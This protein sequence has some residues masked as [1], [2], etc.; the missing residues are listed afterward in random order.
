MVKKQQRLNGIFLILIVVLLFSSCNGGQPEITATPTLAP[1]SVPT[2]T[3]VP[4]TATPEPERVVWIS[5][6]DN[7]ATQ[8]LSAV[9]QSLA[10]SAGIQFEAV[11]SLDSNQINDS[12]RVAVFHTPNYDVSVAAAGHPNTQFIVIGNS[13]MA[14]VDNLTVIRSNP[15]HTLFAAG[16]LSMILSYD[17]RGAGLIASDSGLGD[18]AGWA[19]KNG[20]NYFCGRCSPL[21]PPYVQFPLIVMQPGASPAG[22]WNAGYEGIS[23][24]RLNTIFIDANITDP[25]VYTQMAD[26]G[27]T[28]LGSGNPPEAVKGQW[29]ATVQSDVTGTLVTIWPEIIAGRSAGEVFAEITLTNVNPDLVGDGIVNFFHEMAHDLELGLISTEVQPQ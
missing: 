27:M 7:A 29:A 14:P 25:A 24:N 17:W 13:T 12:I 20:G 8:A 4:P 5:A 28:L 1:T 16:Y 23:E 9:V 19:F 2:D 10:D 11:P 26:L 22:V 3:P 15:L 21:S 6:I 18:N